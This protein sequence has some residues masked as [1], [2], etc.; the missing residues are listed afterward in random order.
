MG[1]EI[2]N[3]LIEEEK[4]FLKEIGEGN[5]TP[6]K[7]NN[8]I[9]NLGNHYTAEFSAPLGNENK[10]EDIPLVFI[11]FECLKPEEFNI[12]FSVNDEGLQAFKSDMPYYL[13]IISTMFQ[14][15][16]KFIKEHSPEVFKIIAQDKTNILLPGQKNR[17]YFSYIE[18]N[19]EK[20]GYRYGHTLNGIILIKIK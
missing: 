14:I 2:Y 15:I 1:R 6:F 18:K 3:L 10:K 11:N 4:R 7:W 12:S 17:I 5:A 8:I 16:K 9:Y 19:A 13:R 20:L